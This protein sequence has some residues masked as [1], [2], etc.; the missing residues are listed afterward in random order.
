MAREVKLY[1]GPMDGKTVGIPDGVDHIH[2]LGAEINRGGFV[3]GPTDIAAA[4]EPI[5]TKEGIYSQVSGYNNEDNF[6]WDG[7][8]K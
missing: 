6:E 4:L 7:W 1:G 8:I 5:T 3:A 2:V